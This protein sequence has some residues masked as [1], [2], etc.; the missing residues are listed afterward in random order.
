MRAQVPSGAGFTRTC[1]PLPDS[2]PDAG[3]ELIYV[4]GLVLELNRHPRASAPMLTGG[5]R[6]WKER[7]QY[8]RRTGLKADAHESDERKYI[9]TRDLQSFGRTTESQPAQRAAQYK[10]RGTLGI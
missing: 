8:M 2:N 7:A 4:G 3:Y 6:N 10:N 9:T 1:S 5:P